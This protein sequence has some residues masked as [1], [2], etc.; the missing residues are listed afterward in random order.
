MKGSMIV[1]VSLGRTFHAVISFLPED[2]IHNCLNIIT[3]NLI[4][5]NDGIKSGKRDIDFGNAKNAKYRLPII[6]IDRM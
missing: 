4:C 3:F 6:H 2:S 1:N 5:G